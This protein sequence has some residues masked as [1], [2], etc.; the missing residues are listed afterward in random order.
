MKI[1]LHNPIFFFLI[2][3][4]AGCAT[5]SSYIVTMD[6]YLQVETGETR[7]ELIQKFG[8]PVSIEAHTDGTEIYTYIER[9]T[10]N[11]EVMKSTTYCFTIKEGKVVDK[12]AKVV[13]RT[14]S[15]DSNQMY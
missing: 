3:L 7:E 9:L 12:S 14:Q 6:S 15:V 1:S 8:E 11:G 4:C 10:M 2:L 5:Y 13:D